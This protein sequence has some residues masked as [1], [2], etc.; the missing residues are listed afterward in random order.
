MLRFWATCGEES[1]WIQQ[2]NVPSLITSQQ[3][4]CFHL[5]IFIHF[6]LST[7]I[8]NIYINIPTQIVLKS[9]LYEGK[10]LY[11]P[12]HSEYW[13]AK[14]RRHHDAQE[15]LM[16]Q[17]C[18]NDTWSFLGRHRSWDPHAPPGPFH[19]TLQPVRKS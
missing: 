2:V 6:S 1:T 4:H 10:L 17:I 12:S 15:F 16:D 7:Y 13:E 5:W 11:I 14:G 18:G 9:D 8:Q 19:C 3:R